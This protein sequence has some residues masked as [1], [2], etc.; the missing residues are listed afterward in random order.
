MATYKISLLSKEQKQKGIVSYSSGNHAQAVA[1]ASL[2]HGIKA[3]I[4]MPN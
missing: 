3:T 2:N 4:V 1:L